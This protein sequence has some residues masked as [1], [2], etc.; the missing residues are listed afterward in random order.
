MGLEKECQANGEMNLKTTTFWYNLCLVGKGVTNRADLMCTRGSGKECVV[1][2]GGWGTIGRLND[3]SYVQVRSG[4]RCSSWE[5]AS[6]RLTRK[7]RQK[8]HWGR[9]GQGRKSFGKEAESLGESG[10]AKET[11]R[12]VRRK[13]N[14]K[15]KNARRKYNGAVAETSRNITKRSGTE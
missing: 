13:T 2:E 11:I 1:K 4:K 7:S 9:R 3:V 5:A 15:S 14:Y 10:C 6:P 8:K 12:R